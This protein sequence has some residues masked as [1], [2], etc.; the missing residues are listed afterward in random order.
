MSKVYKTIIIDDEPPARA[1]LLT[2]LENF[3]NTFQVIAVA[4]DALEAQ[5]KIEV[6]KPDLIFLDIEMPEVSGFEMLERL[7]NI[8]I[9]I[10]CT[11][12]DQYSL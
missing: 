9:V 8:P 6:L 10:F 5:E 11:A 3:P 2:L 7:K 4:E 12:Y 1:R